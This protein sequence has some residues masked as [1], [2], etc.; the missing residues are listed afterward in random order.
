[1]KA[2][3]LVLLCATSASAQPLAVDKLTPALPKGRGRT[4]VDVLSYGTALV[5]LVLDTRVAWRS[6]RRGR[7][8]ALEGVRLGAVLGVTQILKRAIHRRRPCAPACGVDDPLASF[9]SAHTAFAFSARGGPRFV[10][11]FGL[12]TAAGRVEADKHYLTDVAA[13]A[14]VGLAASFIR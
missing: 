8:V 1:M 9:P 7:A 14:A 4:L 5:P 6:D 2:L 13:G 11:L 3:V 12:S 10:L